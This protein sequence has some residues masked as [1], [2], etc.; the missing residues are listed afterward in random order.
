M[1]YIF[2]TEN[3]IKFNLKIV[4]QEAIIINYNQLDRSSTTESQIKFI[5]KSKIKN[6]ICET[7]SIYKKFK[8]KLPNHNVTLISDNHPNHKNITFHYYINKNFKNSL[9]YCLIASTISLIFSLF[10]IPISYTIIILTTQ[11]FIWILVYLFYVDNE[12]WS[13]FCEKYVKF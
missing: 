2:I 1:K 9:K 5:H 4:P 12:P 8:E 6:I 10:F 3:L 7:K 11:F 13:K